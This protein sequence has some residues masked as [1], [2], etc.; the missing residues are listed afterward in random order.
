VQY[1][2]FARLASLS[3]NLRSSHVTSCS[4]GAFGNSSGQIPTT[5]NDWYVDKMHLLAAK[6]R[7]VAAVSA[8]LGPNSAIHFS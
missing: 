4:A 6:A 7:L 8:S 3:D 1:P 2:D 5:A